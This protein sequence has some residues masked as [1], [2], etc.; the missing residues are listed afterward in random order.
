VTRGGVTQRICGY[1]HRM[2][3]AFRI[4]PMLVAAAI[5]ASGCL[6]TTHRIPNS[7]VQRLAQ[8]PP[9]QRG[10]SVRVVQG[11]VTDDQPPSAPR[12]QGG[13]GG[14][15]IV[16]GGGGGHRHRR[17]AGGSGGAGGAKGSKPDLAKSKADKAEFY[18]IL[19]VLAAVGLAVTEGARYDGWVEISPNHPVHLYGP[20]G[21]YGWVPLAELNAEDAAWAQRAYIRPQ[22]GPWRELGRAPLNRRGWTYSMLMGAGEIPSSVGTNDPGFLSH[23][24]IGHF[25]SRE[26]GLVFDIGLGWRE[27]D[28]ANTV[29]NSRWSGELQ[30]LPVSA[31]VIHAGGFAQAGTAALFDDGPGDDERGLIYGGGALLQLEL[32]TRLAITA[33]AGVV[34]AHGETV[35]DFTAGVSVY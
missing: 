1:A 17:R 3:R 24:Q 28:A 6:S 13:G 25:M 34:K 11:F 27:D 31:G 9:E 19:A 10:A 7:E 4:V 14:V 23:I 18:I 35:S 16:T 21:Q 30:V 22:E 32:T 29:F 12:A 20:H 2:V 8:I 15:I 33:R 26:V 5:F